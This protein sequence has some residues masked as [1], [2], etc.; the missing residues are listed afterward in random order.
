MWAI[1]TLSLSSYAQESTN[2][3]GGNANGTGGSVAYSVGQT[4]FNTA[5]SISGI[6][7]QGVQQAYEIF[8]LG[9][10]ILDEIELQV[11]PNPTTKY[12]I[13]KSI[14]NNNNNTFSYLLFD[15]KGKLLNSEKKFTRQTQIN[16]IHLP[17]SHYILKVKNE[18][19]KFFR[20]Y[21]IIKY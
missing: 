8:Q 7:S 9:E 11:F 13:I 19:N 12:I 21:K 15:Q 4:F 1:L 10:N 18:N 16:M 3:T 17:S 2:T 6:E 5:T 14:K 20:S